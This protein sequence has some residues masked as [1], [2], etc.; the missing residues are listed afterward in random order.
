MRYWFDTE[1]IECGPAYP[2][3]FLSLGMVAEDGRELYVQRKNARRDVESSGN[4]WLIDNVLPHLKPEG[5]P[6][7]LIAKR[8]HAF[9]DPE[10]FGKPE[11]WAYYADYD[12]VVFCQIFGRMIDL[13]KGFPMY[14]RDLKQLL[15]EQDLRVTKQ[16]PSTEHSALNDARWTRDAWAE[17]AAALRT[18]ADGKG[19]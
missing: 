12:W 19:E 8:I 15:D 13:P 17:A 6:F 16:D 3:H 18:D 10:R 4:E 11:F 14:C 5:T 9:V 7:N 2:I 1:F